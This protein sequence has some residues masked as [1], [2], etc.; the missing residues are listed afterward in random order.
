MDIPV[1][2]LFLNAHNNVSKFHRIT[3]RTTKRAKTERGP[4]K[5]PSKIFM[6]AQKKIKKLQEA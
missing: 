6:K 3:N 2:V 1:I 5:V 4:S